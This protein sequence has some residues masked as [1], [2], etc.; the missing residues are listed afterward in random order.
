MSS[1]TPDERS[2]E[3]VVQ[4]R[5]V[6]LLDEAEQIVSRHDG[7][8]QAHGCWCAINN[9]VQWIKIYEDHKVDWENMEL[10]ISQLRY[11]DKHG[12]RT[13]RNFKANV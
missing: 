4:Q 11:I 6:R 1:D 5:L 9:E 13:P 3:G 12:Q 8:H 10:M 2:E 7:V